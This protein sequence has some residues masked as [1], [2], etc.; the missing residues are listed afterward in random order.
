MTTIKL[1]PGQIGVIEGVRYKALDAH[2]LCDGCDFEKNG[3]CTAPDYLNCIHLIYKE[4]PED[5]N[6]CD[7]YDDYH[8][9]SDIGI[10]FFLFFIP[11]GLVIL[12]GYPFYKLTKLIRNLPLTPSEGGGNSKK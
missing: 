6:Y 1:L 8:R 11:I 4:V 12:I 10:G 7:T 9:D 5:E 3:G 2:H